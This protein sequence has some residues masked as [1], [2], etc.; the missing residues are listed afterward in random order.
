MTRQA[1]N[2]NPLAL[3]ACKQRA[4][5]EDADAIALPVLCWFDAAKRGQCTNTGLN[6][7]TT[8]V[9][10]AMHIAA[11]T[12][13]KVLDD[14]C[15]KG[16]DMLYK[17]AGRPGDLLALTTPEYAALKKVFGWYVRALPNCEV[18]ILSAA[19]AK[20]EKIMGA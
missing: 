19:C 10:I 16:Y 20:T 12:K 18:A 8:H 13:S 1:P 2:I 7:L 14:I 5:Q 4:G 11:M 6:H 3:I 9:L 17:A 15:K